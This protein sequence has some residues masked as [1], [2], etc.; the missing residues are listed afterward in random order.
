[1]NLFNRLEPIGDS[2]KKM[3]TYTVSKFPYYT[4]HN[5]SHSQNVEEILN[6]L[7]PDEIK[8][9][10]NDYEIF[11]LLI[12]A[13]LHDWGMVASKEEDAEEVRKLH[14]IRTE[15]N[16]EHF[17]D[18]INLSLP[19]A[20]IAGRICRGHRDDDLFD[21][22]YD[23]Q[24]LGSNIMIRVRF[25]TAL[26]R[27]ADECDITAN[28][29][30][31]II[32]YMIKPQGASD[33]EFKKHLSISGIGK[34]S[35]YKLLI[36]GVAKTPRGVQVI[37]GVKKQIQKQLNS[38]KTILAKH[39]VILDIVETQ[40]DTRG[41]IN[42]P[43][44]FH[45]DRRA[46]VSLLIGKTLYSRKDVAVRELL[47]NAI[48]TCRLR[49]VI[50]ANYKPSMN[51]EL[52][53]DYV[54]FEDNGIGMSFNDAFTFLSKKG[55][56]F[57]ISEYLQEVLS[58]KEFDPLS[59]F[60]I[61]VLSSFMIA[62]K[63]I[64]ESKKA[65]CAPCRFTITDLA[66]GW[67]YEEG[68]RKD[69]GTEF[70]IFFNTQAKGMDIVKSL[71]HYAK[72]VK[73]PI[74]IKN[75]Q[76]GEE[77]KFLQ[78]WS[79]DMPEVKEQCNRDAIEKTAGKKPTITMTIT[80]PSLEASFHIFDK[81]LLDSDKNCF[82]L[83]H[84]IY[85]GNFELFPATR[86]N[87]LALIDCRSNLLDLKVSRE[88]IVDNEKFTN[89]LDLIYD[90]LLDTI[91]N[92]LGINNDSLSGVT[93]TQCKNFSKLI[94]SMFLDRMGVKQESP[95]TL[96]L[97][98]FYEKKI[99][100]VLLKKGLT[101]LRGDQIK[102]QRF[103]K[104]THYGLPVLFC[105]EH[106]KLISEITLLKID[107][108]EAIV[109]DLEPHFSFIQPYPRKFHCAFCDIFGVDR[110]DRI[111]CSRLYSFLRTRKFVR[112]HTAI[113]SL[114]PEGSFFA[115]FPE[116]LR[117]LTLELKSF[118]FQPSPSDLSSSTPIRAI[119]YSNLVGRELACDKYTRKFYEGQLFAEEKN[120]KLLSAG[121]FI[122]DLEDRILKFII[123]KAEDVLAS[124]PLKQLIQRY[125]IERALCN[126]T[127]DIFTRRHYRW[128]TNTLLERT[129]AEIL[130]YSQEC[131]P[132]RERMGKL[133]LVYGECL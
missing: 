129:I 133:A 100:P 78:N 26:L 41:F 109:F 125:L 87:W 14:H 121:Y 73:I 20:R 130:G 48:D 27:I 35:P 21:S 56:S 101:F 107:K 43:I 80:A 116:E 122:Y 44:E 119:L 91:N 39:G 11:L 123:S 104:I 65:N 82:L 15:V 22:R 36:S 51:I 6:W 9:K 63:M 18:R 94:D 70:T 16:F 97:Q 67:K 62:D 38:A 52:D 117:S 99:Y 42:K 85:V 19:E 74:Y 25:L 61:G 96:W 92:H 88:D 118:E 128:H 86:Q 72:N 54:S 103:S 102:S 131:I 2:A 3:L 115:K 34:P 8:P 126:L 76:T 81:H 55:H 7:V 59:K 33:E 32:Y 124:E 28:R 4:P 112:E 12:S 95:Q 57:Y 69:E 29:T 89:F 93:L 105:E 1:M 24:F 108:D 84:G 79:F 31:E 90:N 47:S 83:T 77:Q 71:K 132:L 127:V 68:A 40:I 75:A 10:M 110:E 60:G 120:A 111:A 49:K 58:G 114:L 106:I 37:D 113:D 5:F 23:D 45:L 17:H 30:P 13:W 66:E 46:I 53:K 98:K 50:N 64:I